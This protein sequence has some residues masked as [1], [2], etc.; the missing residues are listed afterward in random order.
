MDDSSVLEGL[1]ILQ[2][3]EPAGVGARDA[4]ECILLQIERS[5]DAPYIA[6]DVIQKFFT[7]FAE[8]NGR[9]SLQKWM[10]ACKTFKKFP[11]TFKP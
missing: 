11:T 4:R 6:Y 7:E 3:M 8:K 1:E 5:P 2:S 9:K 10:L